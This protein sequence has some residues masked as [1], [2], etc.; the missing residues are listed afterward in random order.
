[1][2]AQATRQD[3]KNT[4]SI[5]LRAAAHPRLLARITK[6]RLRLSYAPVMVSSTSEGTMTAVAWCVLTRHCLV[7]NLCARFASA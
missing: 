1:M 7:P 4:A 5:V 2:P 3:H 6:T